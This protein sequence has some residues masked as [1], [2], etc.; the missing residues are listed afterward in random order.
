MITF[1]MTCRRNIIGMGLRRYD[2]VWFFK[3]QHF[4]SET[5]H[6]THTTVENTIAT[7]LQSSRDLHFWFKHM[8]TFRLQR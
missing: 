3:A 1:I 5:C 7:I 8:Y 6:H 2:G 4:R